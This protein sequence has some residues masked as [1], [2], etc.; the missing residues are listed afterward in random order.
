MPQI[1]VDEIKMM[2]QDRIHSL[3]IELECEA[4]D[5]VWPQGACIQSNIEQ[6]QNFLKAIEDRENEHHK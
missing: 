3:H 5:S 6:F 4:Y 2:I 1:T